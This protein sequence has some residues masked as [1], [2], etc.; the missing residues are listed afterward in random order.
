M[1]YVHMHSVTHP[2]SFLHRAGAVALNECRG[3]ADAMVR[4]FDERR[5]FLYERL[6]D[7]KGWTL[8]RPEGAFYLFPDIRGTG[9]KSGEVKQRLVEAGVEVVQGTIFPRGEGYIRISY[10]ASLEN[11]AKAADRV[12]AAFGTA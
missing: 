6:K 5:R 11:L 3:E 12:V 1:R 4:K 9:L 10:A 2:S 7:I 8:P